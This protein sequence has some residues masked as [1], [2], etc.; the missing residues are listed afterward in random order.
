MRP[1][2]REGARARQT[3][4]PAQPAAVRAEHARAMRGA[5]AVMEQNHFVEML[6]TGAPR[7]STYENRCRRAVVTDLQRNGCRRG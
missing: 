5:K 7:E 4:K 6:S 3:S 2:D 1:R